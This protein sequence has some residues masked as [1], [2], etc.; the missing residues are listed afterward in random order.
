MDKF[1]HPTVYNGCNYL[2]MLGLKFIHVCQ[3]G[4]WW[5]HIVWLHKTWS[6]MTQVSQHWFRWWLCTI[7]CQ[8]ITWTN[9]DLSIQPQEN[10]SMKSYSKFRHFH[11]R[12]IIWKCHLQN[13]SH[14]V[15]ASMC[16]YQHPH[17]PIPLHQPQWTPRTSYTHRPVYGPH[18]FLL[19]TVPMIYSGIYSA[20]PAI[21][22]KNQFLTKRRLA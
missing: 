7:R 17:Q 18:P 22:A 3:R 6:S 15:V 14:F 5:R 11:S 16:Q 8:A 4:P 19:G 12:K 1:S 2:S 13:V 20:M 9:A 10:I 21:G